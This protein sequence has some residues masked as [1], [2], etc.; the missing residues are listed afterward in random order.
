VRRKFPKAVYSAI[1]LLESL[2]CSIL[3]FSFPHIEQIIAAL[4]AIDLCEAST[5]HSKDLETRGEELSPDVRLYL[6]QGLMIP[7]T[8]YVN[9]LR[10]RAEI[11]QKVQT[12]FNALDIIIVPT[13]PTI[14]PKIG[15]TTVKLE[16]VSQEQ[17]I[18]IALFN[19][20]SPFNLTGLPALSVPCGFSNGLPIGMQI[21]GP[22]DDESTILRVG[23]AYEQ[24]TDWHLMF[25]SLS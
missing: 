18:N 25:P 15:T 2:G 16:G 1:D 19:N 17:D 3:I 24:S 12:L 22:L 8:Y 6:E 10:I 5:Y 23:Q 11:L 4:F 13:V 20:T 7:A 9:A 21:V 14:A